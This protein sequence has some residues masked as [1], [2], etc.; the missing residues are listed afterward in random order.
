MNLVRYGIKKIISP[1]TFDYLLSKGKWLLDSM[2]KEAELTREVEKLYEYQL[3]R[4]PITGKYEYKLVYIGDRLTDRIIFLNGQFKNGVWDDL[5]IWVEGLWNFGIW[6]FGVWEK[7]NWKNGYWNKGQ[8]N[9]GLWENGM[10]YDGVWVDGVWKKGIWC[11]GIWENG[12]WKNGTWKNGVWNKGVWENGK[13]LGG[14]WKSGI[15]KGGYDMYGNFHKD[16]PSK[17][18]NK[19]YL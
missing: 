17:W 14:V 3:V 12:I 4:N 7:G 1:L 6:K 19:F 18:R 8:W 5:G 11:N 2:L 9:S 10:W 15:W 16:N 13:W